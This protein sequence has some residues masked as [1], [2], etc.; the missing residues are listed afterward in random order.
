MVNGNFAEFV[1][2]VIRVA[3]VANG[4]CST[5]QHLERNI[6]DVFSDLRQTIPRAFIQE[7]HRHVK[8]GPLKWR[9][10][11]CG[12]DS[13]L[14]PKHSGRSPNCPHLQLQ[15]CLLT[16]PAFQ[17]VQIREICRHKR[18]DLSKVGRAHTSGEQGLVSIS[19][20]RVHQQ[21]RVGL[22]DGAREAF[23]AFFRENVLVARRPLTEVVQRNLSEEEGR[24]WM[25]VMLIQLEISNKM[26]NK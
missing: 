13:V 11:D 18:R 8:R 25:M 22:A 20:R 1:N 2:D 23:W 7:P 12:V 10:E 15:H 14:N 21:Q 16:S 5:Q 9:A 26:F 6:R 3:G 17:A 24:M 19:K 4:V